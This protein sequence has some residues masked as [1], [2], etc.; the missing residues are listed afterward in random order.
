MILTTK[1][2]ASTLTQVIT[3]VRDHVGDPNG[4]R[5][6]SAR[7][8]R[9]IDGMAQVMHTEASAE[10][11]RP[12]LATESL[13]LIPGADSTPLPPGLVTAPIFSV[14]DVTDP[15]LPI[16]IDHADPEHLDRFY[17]GVSFRWALVGGAIAIR[18]APSTAKTLRLRYVAE[19]VRASTSTAND[20]DQLPIAPKHEELLSLGAAIALDETG[21]QVPAPRVQRFEFL[22]ALF[23]KTHNR[24]PGREY[25]QNVR[26]YY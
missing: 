11:P 22:W 13:T 4:E 1:A 9:E 10:D 14:E 19:F 5:H 20:Y 7:I 21:S 8:L 24:T 2:L 17:D 18:P 26:S 25:V 12:F 16:F 23:Q 3:R 6:T 15:N